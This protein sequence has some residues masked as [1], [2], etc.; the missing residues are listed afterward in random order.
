MGKKGP[1]YIAL[2]RPIRMLLDEHVS[3]RVVG[4]VVSRY[5]FE[6][7]IFVFAVDAVVP[8]PNEPEPAGRVKALDS[9]IAVHAEHVLAVSTQHK[10]DV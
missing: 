9:R 10:D 1:Y 8:H 4:L 5:T 2:A 6:E 7:D 3:M